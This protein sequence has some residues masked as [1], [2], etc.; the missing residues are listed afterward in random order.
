MFN[1]VCLHRIVIC[2]SYWVIRYVCY[3]TYTWVGIHNLYESSYI[4][5]FFHINAKGLKGCSNISHSMHHHW[6]LPRLTCISF[7]HRCDISIVNCDPFRHGLGSGIQLSDTQ[8]QYS[9]SISNHPLT[10]NTQ[11]GL[12]I[13]TYKAKRVCCFV[14][15]QVIH[16][17]FSYISPIHLLSFF[18]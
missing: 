4:Y 17:M 15:Y 5:L 8:Y 18:R 11:F 1:A 12:F 7:Q 16:N 6:Y 2:D 10:L 3:Y 14:C 9:L 13:I